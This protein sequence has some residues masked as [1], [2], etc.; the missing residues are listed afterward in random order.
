MACIIYSIKKLLSAFMLYRKEI[1]SFHTEPK[2][3]QTSIH[4]LDYI[5]IEIYSKE[6]FFEWISSWIFPWDKFFFKSSTILYR[7]VQQYL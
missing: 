2:D 1:W 5:K 7:L 3:R 6:S 4:T